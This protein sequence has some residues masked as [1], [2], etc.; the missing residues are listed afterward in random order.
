MRQRRRAQMVFATPHPDACL[1]FIVGICQALACAGVRLRNDPI[2]LEAACEL[3]AAMSVV[4]MLCL[5]YDKWQVL[6]EHVSTFLTAQGN[7][8]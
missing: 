2:E 1:G 3:T 7:Q 5:A 8:Q 6:A 4:K